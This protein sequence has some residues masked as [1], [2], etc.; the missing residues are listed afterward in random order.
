MNNTALIFG[1]GKTGRGFAAHLAFLGG[2]NIILIDK[3]L[4][5][6][7]ELKTAGEYSIQVLNNNEKS[8]TIPVT[9]AYHITDSS[10]HDHFTNTSLAFTAVFGNNLEELGGALAAALRKRY[11]ENPGQLLT[12]ITCE[13]LADAAGFLKEM[14]IRN[15]NEDEEKWVSEKVGFSEVYHIQNMP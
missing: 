4:R 2:Y 9:A 1:A 14:V 15:L 6:V 7:S 3:N 12:I 5:L 10:W 11:Q 13:N 8:C